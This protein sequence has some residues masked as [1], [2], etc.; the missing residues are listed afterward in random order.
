M[1]DGRMYNGELRLA[2]LLADWNPR[3][4]LIDWRESA[5][6]GRKVMVDH[7]GR[8]DDA[9]GLEG[10]VR[11]LSDEM[12]HHARHNY[13]SN[14]QDMERKAKERWADEVDVMQRSIDEL[15]DAL[16][17]IHNRNERHGRSVRIK[18]LLKHGRIQE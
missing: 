17:G 8:L 12:R 2:S 13:G 16:Q 10:E 1:D 11:T 15:L 4:S 5:I 6:Q 7:L 14:A 9:L 3:K 18:L